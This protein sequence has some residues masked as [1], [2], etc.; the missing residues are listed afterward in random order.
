MVDQLKLQVS[1]A[2]RQAQREKEERE[3]RERDIEKLEAE[4]KLTQQRL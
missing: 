1:D 3:Q 2:L 4:S